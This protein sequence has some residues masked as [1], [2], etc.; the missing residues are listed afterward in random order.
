MEAGPVTVV[1]RDESGEEWR[2]TD[3][4]PTDSGRY[5]FRIDGPDGDA[6]QIEADSREE[7]RARLR[8]AL[9]DRPDI[10]ALLP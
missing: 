10:L 8:E 9:G 4:S 3:A 6:L 5:L 7:V 2:V 1:L